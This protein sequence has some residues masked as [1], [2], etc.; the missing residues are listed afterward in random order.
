MR[1]F[2]VF[3]CVVGCAVFVTGQ[4][5]S[6]PVQFG[7]RTITRAAG[8]TTLQLRGSVRIVAGSVVIVADEADARILGQ[9]TPTEF[10][11]RGHVHLSTAGSD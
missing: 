3:L 5:V 10:D 6:A 8:G 4:T 1:T 2:L 11:L 7:A 9:G